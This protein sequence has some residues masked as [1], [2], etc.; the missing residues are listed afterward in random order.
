M[1]KGSEFINIFGALFYQGF[2]GKLNR[3]SVLENSVACVSILRCYKCV[4]LYICDL[5]YS[6]SV[7]FNYLYNIY[8]KNRSKLN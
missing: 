4:P 5:N 6:V 2:N 8:L 7:Y 3:L 1:I